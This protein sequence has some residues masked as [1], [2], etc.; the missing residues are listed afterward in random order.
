MDAWMWGAIL[1]PFGA[2]VIF[3]CIALPIRLAIRRYMKD[4][5]LKEQILKPRGFTESQRKRQL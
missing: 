4:G 1:K 3:G 5:W 2:L